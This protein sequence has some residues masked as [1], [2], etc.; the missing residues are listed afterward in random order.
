ML[1]TVSLVPSICGFINVSA[2]VSLTLTSNLTANNVYYASIAIPDV[3]CLI[4]L[5]TIDVLSNVKVTRIKT[6][7]ITPSTIQFAATITSDMK[8][9][10]P[11]GNISTVLVIKNYGSTDSFHLTTYS[12]LF[13][14]EAKLSENDFEISANLEITLKLT[15]TARWNAING[16]T[17]TI[18][19]IAS[20]TT[21][22]DNKNFLQFSTKV[23]I[24]IHS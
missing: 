16:L 7:I 13:E 18:Q 6:S 10:V 3:L 21:G 22:G 20:R 2:L 12:S 9:I 11:G 17:A 5:E 23:L 4:Q 24:L 14:V 8:S 15:C 1:S 19:I